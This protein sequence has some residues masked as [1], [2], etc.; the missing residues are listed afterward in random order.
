MYHSY[1]KSVTVGWQHVPIAQKQ[2]PIT[3]LELDHLRGIRTW[4]Q[5]VSWIACRSLNVFCFSLSVTTELTEPSYDS[6]DSYG[7]YDSYE[8]RIN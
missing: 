7:S 1:Y 5:G 3:A 6:Y 4:L 2:P 8:L